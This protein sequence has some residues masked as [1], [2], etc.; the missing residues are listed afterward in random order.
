MVNE[1]IELSQEDKDWLAANYPAIM[2]KD[3]EGVPHLSG[4]L[5][6]DMIYDPLTGQSIL[7][8][9]IIDPADKFHINDAYE[10]DIALTY[11]KNSILPIVKEVGNR[12]ENLAGTLNIPITDLHANKDNSLCVCARQAERTY[13]PEKFEL[14]VF[15]QELLIPFFYSHS[16]YEK[17]KERPWGEHSHGAL[18][19]LEYY[20]DQ[21]VLGDE[22]LVRS[23][24]KAL[25]EDTNQYRLA[26]L[27]YLSRNNIQAHWRCV[28]GESKRMDKCHP[29][30]VFALRK[31]LND[32]SA[33]GLTIVD[34]NL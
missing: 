9:E 16:F 22:Q 1:I 11:A 17:Y 23:T 21:N 10:I 29:E 18:G 20:T 5:E 7:N 14:S 3:M 2:L 26:Y 15:V 12:F 13:F 25:K 4:T 8:S 24:L 6:F 27:M 31:L 32:A 34:E 33:L 19:I 28:C 30:A